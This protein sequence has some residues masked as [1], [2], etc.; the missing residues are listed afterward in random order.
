MTFDTDPADSAAPDETAPWLRRVDIVTVYGLLVLSRGRRLRRPA[1]AGANNWA[2]PCVPPMAMPRSASR[3]WNASAT[4]KRRLSARDPVKDNGWLPYVFGDPPRSTTPPT[5]SRAR[6]CSSG[7]D[8]GL[9]PWRGGGRTVSS[10][11]DLAHPTAFP[12]H[13][14]NHDRH[15]FARS[16]VPSVTGFLWFG[17]D[18]R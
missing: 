3:A 17:Q 15:A 13:R 11:A 7:S 10:A 16:H 14:N 2:M 1:A 8:N 12:A 6:G 4:G 18:G 9:I 5:S